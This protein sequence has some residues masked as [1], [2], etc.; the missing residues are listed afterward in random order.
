MYS[1]FEGGNFQTRT[2]LCCTIKWW[3]NTDIVQKAQQKENTNFSC[4]LWRDSVSVR[5]LCSRAV[6]E[7]L[8]HNTLLVWS[9]CEYLLDKCK[10]PERYGSVRSMW[11][12]YITVFRAPVKGWCHSFHIVS[13]QVKQ[14]LCSLWTEYERYR[15]SRHKTQRT[16]KIPKGL[17]G[18]QT[19]LGCKRKTNHFRNIWDLNHLVEIENN[20]CI[21]V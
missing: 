6:E 3:N 9:L 16:M 2:T 18:S 12:N 20:L 11:S 7:L 13:T 10:G 14:E 15:K 1:V 4:E 17:T 19:R 5:R 21:V 8:N